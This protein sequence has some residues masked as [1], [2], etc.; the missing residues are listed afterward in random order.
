MVLYLW[1]TD[2]LKLKDR[3][4]KNL[5]IFKIE[6]I[7]PRDYAKFALKITPFDLKN[8]LVVIEYL[9]KFD[10]L[11]VIASVGLGKN[12]KDNYDSKKE[13]EKKEILAFFSKHIREHNFHTGI[14]QDFSGMEG[15]RFLM[16]Q[17]MSIQSLLD[18]ISESIFLLEDLGALLYQADQSLKVPK[19]SEDANNMFR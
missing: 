3:I 13:N 2:S 11:R 6:E 7:K 17:N 8:F 10:M 19:I 18:T 12:L 14:P 9:Q 16:V 15:F 4:L 5:T 1:L